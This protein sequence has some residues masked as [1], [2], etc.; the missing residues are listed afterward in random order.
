[1]NVILLGAP[2]A[3][4]GTQAVKLA[5]KYNIGY[6]DVQTVLD[7][8]LK[9]GSVYILSDD[10]VHPKSVG[11]SLIARAIYRHPDFRVIFHD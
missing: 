10:R 3:G 4:K 6:I 2:G 8:Y 1:M 7:E 5:E 9:T 11:I